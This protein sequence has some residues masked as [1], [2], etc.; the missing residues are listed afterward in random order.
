MVLII[1]GLGIKELELFG[2]HCCVSTWHINAIDKTDLHKTQ[3]FL[4][5]ITPIATDPHVSDGYTN[6]TGAYTLLQTDLGK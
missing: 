3:R 5:Q 6:K 2:C 1:S 4:K